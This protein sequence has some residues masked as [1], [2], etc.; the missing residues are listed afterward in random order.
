MSAVYFAISGDRN[1]IKIGRTDYMRDRILALRSYYKDDILCCAVIDNLSHYQSVKLEKRLHHKFKFC[2]IEGE[3]FERLP[4]EN[5]LVKIKNRISYPR[6]PDYC[7]FVFNL[8][9][10]LVIDRDFIKSF[11]KEYELDEIVE[12]YI[13]KVNGDWYE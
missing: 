3:W 9:H 13:L 2:N 6:K 1:R 4:I 5:Y 8:S 11:P 12:D 7:Y 10:N